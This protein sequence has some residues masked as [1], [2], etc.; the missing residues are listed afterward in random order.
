MVRPF[1]PLQSGLVWRR[2][3]SNLRLLRRRQRGSSSALFRQLGTERGSGRSPPVASSMR[4]LATA[5]M[6]MIGSILV[7]LAT[8]AFAQQPSRAPSAAASPVSD[9][10]RTFV[11]ELYPKVILAAEAMPAE[12]YATRVA[13]TTLTFRESVWRIVDM[14]AWMCFRLG[15][16]R[17]P[18]TSQP[19]V[20]R[21]SPK[22]SLV[23]RMR[24]DERYCEAQLTGLTDAA[25]AETIRLDLR[26]DPVGTAP[27]IPRG[28][29]LVHAT[30][31]LADSYARLAETLRQNGIVP[32][33][34]SSA[35]VS[36]PNPGSG[37]MR[38]D[39]AR[40]PREGE[41]WG[42]PGF[43]FTLSDARRETPYTVTSD[44][45]GPYVFGTSNVLA[46]A[47]SRAGVMVLGGPSTDGTPRRAIRVDLSQP[48]PGGGGVARGIVTDSSHLEVAAQWRAEP[49]GERRRAYALVDIPEG[50]TVSAAQLDVQFH[51]DGVVHVLQMGPQPIG[52]CFSDSPAISGAGT[53]SGTITRR[54][55]N[56][57]VV[58]LPPGS[59]GRLYDVHLS[60]PH[61]VDR[62][63]YRVAL[64]FVITRR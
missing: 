6:I 57:W 62:G 48:V 36:D 19:Q 21:D 28:A 40:P 34:P 37:I 22:D 51:I 43:A 31:Y 64:R 7:V 59:V 42:G 53:T 61:A 55:A 17:M 38:C 3:A 60:Y 24:D 41:R 11:R 33:K 46:L 35:S 9:A 63:L 15:N 16:S 58:D 5:R 10:F 50:T 32:P 23:L 56:T 29:A 4:T 8:P 47:A 1:M 44:G 14:G 12:K 13:T 52:H 26:P 49:N 39:P 45:R 20:G 2:G 18:W 25:L 30:A 54:D 27:L